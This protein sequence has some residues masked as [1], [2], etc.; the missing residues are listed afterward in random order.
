MAKRLINSTEAGQLVA[1]LREQ[2]GIG[3]VAT[4]VGDS[5]RN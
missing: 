4:A 3:F 5:R 1:R 2:P